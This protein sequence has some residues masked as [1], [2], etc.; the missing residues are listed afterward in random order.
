MMN[1]ILTLF[2][3]RTVN[4]ILSL[5]GKKRSNKGLMMWASLLGLVI[6]V[7][8]WGSKKNGNES[9]QQDPLHNIME[10]FQNQPNSTLLKALTA[11]E[12]SKELSPDNNPL[13]DE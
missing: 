6:S 1:R 10:N 9:I 2:D 13:S 5:F 3:R 7:A 8:A 4:M 11:T 12:F